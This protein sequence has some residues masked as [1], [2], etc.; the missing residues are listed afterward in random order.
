MGQENRDKLT[1]ASAGGRVEL[2]NGKGEK[3]MASLQK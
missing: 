2:G 3:N 1:T